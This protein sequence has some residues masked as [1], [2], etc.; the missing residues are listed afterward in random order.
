VSELVW[1]CHLRRA[2]RFVLLDGQVSTEG[3]RG[4]L[5]KS[6]HGVESALSLSDR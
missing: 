1:A 5:G 2:E 4:A 6:S 3:V